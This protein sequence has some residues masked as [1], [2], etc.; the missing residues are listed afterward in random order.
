[1]LI[2]C[3]SHYKIHSVLDIKIAYFN[4]T[5]GSILKRWRFGPLR[6][7]TGELNNY[8]FVVNVLIVY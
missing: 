1:M 5:L 4:N 2:K 7:G 3:I 6:T 8:D